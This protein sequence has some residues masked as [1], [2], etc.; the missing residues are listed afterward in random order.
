[1]FV[2]ETV[3]VVSCHA[4]GEV[5]DVIVGGVTPP[6]GS[7]IWEQRNY[8]ARDERLRDYIL[9][10]P[11][12]GVFRHCNLIVP[13]MHPEADMG[14]IIMEPIHSPPMSGSNSM[15]V[16]TVLL[17]TGMLPMV[18]PITR[19]TLEAPGG[20]VPVEALCKNGK[21]EYVTVQNLPSF[22]LGKDHEITVEGI[23]A[24][25]V[26]LAFGGDSFVVVNPEAAGVT[27]NRA[28][29]RELA[30][31]GQSITKAANE[32]LVFTHPTL[33]EWK[34]ISFCLYAGEV[35]RNQKTLSAKSVLAIE[36][37]KIDRSAT[38][39]AV[40]AR[41]AL[42]HSENVMSLDDRFVATSLIDSIFEG[43]I[44]G[45]SKVGEIPAIIPSI[46]GRAWL[47]GTHQYRLDSTDPYPSGYRLSDTWPG[48]E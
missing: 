19:I 39:T 7:T 1:M 15:C 27:L 4:E 37:G 5:G 13:A 2:N 23:G 12:G 20:L 9:N 22:S 44:V 29:A 36:P 38:G 18:E 28:H 16:A 30:M 11:R 17:E 47:T 35:S 41:M 31:L 14:F 10:E 40:S 33:P 46:T 6:P 48:A 24:L 26:A 21:V 25:T 8:I 45:T 3:H 43:R 42:L 32:Q 34:H